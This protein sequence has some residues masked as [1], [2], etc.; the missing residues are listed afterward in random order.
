MVLLSAFREKKSSDFFCAKLITQAL[1]FLLE[2]MKKA[3]ID[4]QSIES[5]I[6][7]M[8]DAEGND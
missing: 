7:K 3:G 1:D 5:V 6:R 2:L 8:K 4:S